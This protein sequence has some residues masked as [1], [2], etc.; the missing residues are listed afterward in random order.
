MPA[1]S[2]QGEN[3][4][5]AAGSGLRFSRKRSISAKARPPPAESPEMV[6]ELAGWRDSRRPFHTPSTSSTAAG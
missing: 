2:V 4:A 3:S 6:I 5:A 1:R